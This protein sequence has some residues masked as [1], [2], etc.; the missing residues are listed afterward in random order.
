MAG[1][2]RV[3]QRFN[4]AVVAVLTLAGLNRMAGNTSAAKQAAVGFGHPIHAKY[5]RAQK[6]QRHRGYAY[7]GYGHYPRLK[8]GLWGI[9][10]RRFV[11]SAALKIARLANSEAARAARVRREEGR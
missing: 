2:A 11:P 4:A 6:P 8:D 9:G 10:V 7:P 5:L 3:Q 1:L